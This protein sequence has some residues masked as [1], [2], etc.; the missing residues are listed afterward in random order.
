MN[1]STSDPTTSQPLRPEVTAPYMRWAKTHR[2]AIWDL[3][4]SNLLA[5]TLD[6]L[7]GAREALELAGPAGPVTVPVITTLADLPALLVEG[8]G[9]AVP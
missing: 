1:T 6:D 5:C 3:T 2:R 7:P 8:T 4:G 9:P